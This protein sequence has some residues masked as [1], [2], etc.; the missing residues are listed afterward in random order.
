MWTLLLVAGALAAGYAI[1]KSTG[2][3]DGEPETTD[4][5]PV[6]R[7]PAGSIDSRAFGP[8]ITPSTVTVT[9]AVGNETNLAKNTTSV[10]FF[11]N[12]EAAEQYYRS[13][14]EFFSRHY[15]WWTCPVGF[16]YIA[17]SKPLGE[18]EVQDGMAAIEEGAM[19]HC[20][21]YVRTSGVWD[22]V[23]GA[24][25]E[26]SDPQEA[27]EAP[28]MG[29]SQSPSQPVWVVAI[30]MGKFNEFQTYFFHDQVSADAYFSVLEAFFAQT[31][32]REAFTSPSED[33]VVVRYGSGAAPSKAVR[34]G[35]GG[36]Y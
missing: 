33:V 11:S 12:T 25:S 32:I 24:P 19:F 1:A 14:D 26:P 36:K 4:T 27:P 10:H 28:A 22:V 2:S 3:K 30:L 9:Y 17:M 16:G 29:L 23:G 18:V 35:E 31:S 15:K 13:L 7:P 6:P 8:G 20:T 21:A 5:P 34:Y